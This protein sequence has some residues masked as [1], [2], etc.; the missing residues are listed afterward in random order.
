MIQLTLEDRPRPSR[1]TPT[2]GQRRDIIDRPPSTF[3]R[4]PLSPLH[5]RAG[6]SGVLSSTL[7]TYASNSSCMIFMLGV[8][9]INRNDG[10][11]Q[12]SLIRVSHEW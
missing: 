10:S 9:I 5:T 8:R 3:D 6:R 11:A 1:P 7:F 12:I 2:S 4:H